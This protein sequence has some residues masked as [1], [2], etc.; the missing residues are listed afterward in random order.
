MEKRKRKAAEKRGLPSWTQSLPGQSELHNIASI[1]VTEETEMKS[2][3]AVPGVHE[4]SLSAENLTGVSS[5]R[6]TNGTQESTSQNG[7]SLSPRKDAKSMPPPSVHWRDSQSA[8]ESLSRRS[9]RRMEPTLTQSE[10]ALVPMEEVEEEA[11]NLKPSPSKSALPCRVRPSIDLPPSSGISQSSQPERMPSQPSQLPLEVAAPSTLNV[12]ASQRSDG[13]SALSAKT[14]SPEASLSSS[15]PKPETLERLK[16]IDDIIG[17]LVRHA[18]RP[19]APVAKGSIVTGKRNQMDSRGDPPGSIY[20]DLDE[21]RMRNAYLREGH[22]RIGFLPMGWQEVNNPPM[23]TSKNKRSRDD[24]ERQGDT[25]SDEQTTK[26]RKLKSEIVPAKFTTWKPEWLGKVQCY[27]VNQ[28]GEDMSDE[29]WLRGDELH[30]SADKMK[31]ILETECMYIPSHRID[32][33]VEIAK[34]NYASL[35]AVQA[36]YGNCKHPKKKIRIERYQIK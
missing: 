27:P 16:K 1:I 11:E 23:Q 31:L 33:L 14:L 13:S 15:P 26:R 17:A 8:A 25:G 24:L 2:S 19:E 30:R 32:E 29:V 28:L 4:E 10:A 5:E 18:Q 21:Y 7:L 36:M 3:I 34:K 20:D 35:R 22:D 9:L 12:L 6:I